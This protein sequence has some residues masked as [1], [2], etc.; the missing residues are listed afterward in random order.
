M[1]SNHEKNL[2]THSL[3]RTVLQDFFLSKNKNSTR[4]QYE[5]A[6]KVMRIFSFSKRYSQKTC[7]HEVN[8]YADTL[9]A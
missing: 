4:V 9:S 1:G 5:Q 8:D 6:K 2:K 7:V 3:Y